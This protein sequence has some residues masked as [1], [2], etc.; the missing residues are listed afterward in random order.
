MEDLTPLEEQERARHRATQERVEANYGN[1]QVV[2]QGVRFGM[3]SMGLRKGAHQK[4]GDRPAV[5]GTW[6]HRA[7]RPESQGR[8]KSTGWG[9][10]PAF[11][12]LQIDDQNSSARGG[13]TQP[14]HSTYPPGVQV[15]HDRIDYHIGRLQLADL[16][17]PRSVHQNSQPYPQ[18]MADPVQEANRGLANLRTDDHGPSA[19]IGAHR[20]SQTYS[21]G[22]N[23]PV[24]N[25]SR[26]FANLRINDPRSSTANTT[27]NVKN[28][29]PHLPGMGY[30]H[31]FNP[32]GRDY[33]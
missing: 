3:P 11:H 32:R 7:S 17:S 1:A 19:T 4:M 33:M 16:Y 24:Q 10:G 20:H 25:T 18:G 27:N 23:N 2:D 26:A 6:D 14:G 15:H 13:N 31:V 8:R 9:S 29:N 28:G 22:M 30:R 12:N 5:L 21:P